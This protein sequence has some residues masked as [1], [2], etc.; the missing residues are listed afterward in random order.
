MVLK[1]SGVVWSEVQ[2][3]FGR[4]R[5][6]SRLKGFSLESRVAAAGCCVS[7]GFLVF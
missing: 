7:L 2:V 3:V 4:L 5:A 6:G 1:R